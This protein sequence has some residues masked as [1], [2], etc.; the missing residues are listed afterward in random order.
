LE[1]EVIFRIFNAQN[2]QQ[3]KKKKNRQ[4][5]TL[6]FPSNLAKNMDQHFFLWLITTLAH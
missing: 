4:I 5:S 2:F 3:G 1:D 6:T